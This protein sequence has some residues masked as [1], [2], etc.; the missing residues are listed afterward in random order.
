MLGKTIMMRIN[1]FYDIYREIEIN[2][3]ELNNWVLRMNITYSNKY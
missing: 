1:K 2:I 3:L